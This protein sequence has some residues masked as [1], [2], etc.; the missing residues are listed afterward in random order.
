MTQENTLFHKR[1]LVPPAAAKGGFVASTC[2]IA[3][4]WRQRLPT[5][6]IS[7]CCWSA[8]GRKAS[9]RFV[10]CWTRYAVAAIRGPS[11]ILRVS[12]PHGAAASPPSKALSR[13]SRPRF[14]YECW[15]QL[16]A[17]VVRPSAG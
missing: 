5:L 10:T 15:I 6:H 4:R 16:L 12:F 14:G 1:G 17:A 11:L 13:R 7:A 3:T 9:P 8:D 2:R